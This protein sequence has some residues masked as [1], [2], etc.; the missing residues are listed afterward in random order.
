MFY[1]S[2]REERKID[3]DWKQVSIEFIPVWCGMGA[4]ISSLAFPNEEAR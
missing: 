4:K 3:M 2:R 1:I